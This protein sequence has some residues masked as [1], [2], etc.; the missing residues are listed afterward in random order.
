MNSA[1]GEGSACP[2]PRVLPNLV[3]VCLASVFSIY[4]QRR[5]RLY[6]S[7]RNLAPCADTCDPRRRPPRESQTAAAVN[8]V[9]THNSDPGSGPKSDGQAWD[10]LCYLD[11]I[12]TM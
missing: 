10:M 7:R 5:Q 11:I 1:H 12:N 4:D 3:A 2:H 9:E 6:G 8:D